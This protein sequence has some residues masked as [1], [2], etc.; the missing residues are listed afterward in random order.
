M[1][2]GPRVRWGARGNPFRLN[3]ACKR[4]CRSRSLIEFAPATI[5]AS[6]LVVFAAAFG[7]CTV[8]ASSSSYRPADS[9]SRS[10][11]TRPAVDTRVG[12]VEPLTIV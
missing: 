3:L 2:A 10:A 5:P 6:T 8:S 4:G 7:D 1:G 11:G 9:A 12:F